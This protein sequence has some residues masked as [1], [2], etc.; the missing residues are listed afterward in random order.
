MFHAS[1]I[2]LG[3]GAAALALAGALL[4]QISRS[5]PPTRASPGRFPPPAADERTAGGPQVAVLAGGCFWGVQGVFQHVKG[6]TSAVSGYA[7]GEKPTAHYE[8]V[9]HRH[10]GPRGVG[11]RDVR[12]AQISYG[13]ILQIYFS[14][15]HDPTELN[16][17]GPDSGTQYRS[18]I[19]PQNETRRRWRRPISRS[20]TRRTLSAA[21]SSPSRARQDVLSGGGLPPGLPGAEPDLSLHRLQRPAEGRG[22]EG[23]VPG[24]LS[25]DPVLV[26]GGS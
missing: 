23:D 7:G 5:P 18:A 19:F 11:A 6:V 20:S 8:T 22:A 26:G 16:R 12:P 1:T 25:R 21:R 24:N 14:V 10:H 9:E 17:Q 2:K 4:P 15:A 3:A 13:Q